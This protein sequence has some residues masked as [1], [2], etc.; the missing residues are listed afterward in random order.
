MRGWG[1]QNG[2]KTLLAPL[3]SLL[4]L[5]LE[6]RCEEEKGLVAGHNTCEIDR[7]G[8]QCAEETF[9]ASCGSCLGRLG[10]RIPRS[11]E[12]FFFL[13]VQNAS[14]HTPSFW[15]T[16]L[17]TPLL[18]NRG[19]PQIEDHVQK[20]SVSTFLSDCVV[21]RNDGTQYRNF[22]SKPRRLS[23]SSGPPSSPV[24]FIEQTHLFSPLTPNSPSSFTA[25]GRLCWADEGKREKR[26]R[27]EK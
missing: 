20:T 27:H 18:N 12:L 24:K 26:G 16:N 21:C 6:E 17:E 14:P 9:F 15:N 22:R 1:T 25:E 4:S 13:D 8:K 23:C 19:C 11:V 7:F 2:R 10:K 5:R 3:P